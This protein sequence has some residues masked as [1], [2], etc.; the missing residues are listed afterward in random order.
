MRLLIVT[1]AVDQGHPVLGFFHEWLETFAAQC[2]Q[3]EVICLYEGEHTL[4]AHVRVHSLGK[5]GGIQH[6]VIY[7]VRFLQLVWQLR[8]AYDAVFVHMNPEYVVLAGWFW[9]LTRKRIGL[10]Y[11]HKS[12]TLRL[13]V[14]I[15]FA[16]VVFTASPK[17]MRVE[18]PKKR[19]VGH[20]LPVHRLPLLP[21]PAMQEPI[22]LLTIGRLSPVKRVEL[23][24]GALAHLPDTVQLSI[25]GG[26]AGPSGEAYEAT[27]REMVAELGLDARVQFAGP[28]APAALAAWYERSH[29]FVHASDTGSL[30]KALL[31][32]L[33]RGV[34]V[35]TTNYELAREVGEPLAFAASP[36]VRQLAGKIEAAL[37]ARAWQDPELRAMAHAY[38][39]KRH[40]LNVLIPTMVETLDGNG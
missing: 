29:L 30:D 14:A 16:S 15:F 3:V 6:P 23:L 13:R 18:T 1:Q 34:P 35:V 4:P 22:Q 20:G 38:V 36:V 24:I 17:S 28:Q 8:H 5:E 26:A 9:R 31:E 40:N 2:E 27:L 32:A 11:L 33:V 12:V 39:E 10:W 21:A 37:A 25:V 7:A 19:V